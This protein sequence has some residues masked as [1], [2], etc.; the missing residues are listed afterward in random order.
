MNI[1]TEAKNWLLNH[2]HSESD[3]DFES[4]L[5][6]LSETI[7]SI[8]TNEGYVS[9]NELEYDP[10]FGDNKICSCGHKYY[11][12]F[13]TYDDMAPIGCKYCPCHIFKEKVNFH[14]KILSRDQLEK[15]STKRLLA[16]KNKM[17]QVPETIN[18]D[19]PNVRWNKNDPSWKA[20]Y[21]LV[22]E[23]LA[24]REHVEK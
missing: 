20:L 23:V 1:K 6:S 12:H 11:R 7:Y 3:L 10:N 13:D 8:Y 16:Y 2:G 18:W 5:K 4:C 19:E 9:Y 17:M 24:T 22:K 14:M 15:L 21:S